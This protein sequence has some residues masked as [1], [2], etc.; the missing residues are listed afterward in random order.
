MTPDSNFVSN[1]GYRPRRDNAR[2]IVHKYAHESSRENGAPPH[3]RGQQNGAI[4]TAPVTQETATSPVIQIPGRIEFKAK[5]VILKSDPTDSIIEVPGYVFLYWHPQKPV[6]LW[7]TR[8]KGEV[9]SGDIRS[10]H[11]VFVSLSQ[12][13]VRIHGH[14]K[15]GA[16]F[17]PREYHFDSVQVAQGFK[18]C[19]NKMKDV[20]DSTQPENP[21][22]KLAGKVGALDCPTLLAIPEV[23]QTLDQQVDEANTARQTGVEENEAQSEQSNTTVLIDTS[24]SPIR[25]NHAS[26]SSQ[27]RVTSNT[28]DLEGLVYHSVHAD[29]EDAEPTGARDNVAAN[30]NT[31]ATDN[32]DARNNAAVTDSVATTGDADTSPRDLAKTTTTAGTSPANTADLNSNTMYKI[33]PKNMERFRSG[34]GLSKD[35]KAILSNVSLGHYRDMCRSFHNYVRSLSKIQNAPPGDVKSFAATIV[36]VNHLVSHAAFE[37]L[38]PENQLKTAAV[39][40]YNIHRVITGAR[41]RYTSKQLHAM[42]SHILPEPPAIG[43]FNGHVKL[44]HEISL[45]TESLTA[46]RSKLVNIQAGHEDTPLSTGLVAA[47]PNSATSNLATSNTATSNHIT[48]NSVVPSSATPSSAGLNPAPIAQTPVVKAPVVEAPVVEVPAVEAPAVE[49][50]AF[51]APAFE[52]PAVQAPAVEAPAVQAPA[53]QS[54][55]AQASQ[56]NGLSQE[57]STTTVQSQEISPPMNGNGN[58]RTYPPHIRGSSFGHGLRASRW[59]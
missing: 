23:S 41:I 19:I 44:R 50:P 43:L 29:S 53:I 58:Q 9:K 54:S 46:L 4:T 28:V 55:V 5:V 34:L 10:I 39:V 45:L 24:A 40:Y 11:S 38:G 1:P 31:K 17:A 14:I 18:A 33:N 15:P 21:L 3:L 35:C 49:A 27:S 48:P 16:E 56:S 36:V 42:R 22:S 59:A 52:A 12:V 37:R 47:A 51:E 32:E 7:E 2:V 30:A 8:F 26:S 6:G 25:H 57:A 13:N 20:A